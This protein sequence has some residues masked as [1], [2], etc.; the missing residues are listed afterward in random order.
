LLLKNKVVYYE[1]QQPLNDLVHL[2]IFNRNEPF[3]F[4]KIADYLKRNSDTT[5][6]NPEETKR[7]RI[8]L[9]CREITACGRAFVKLKHLLPENLWSSIQV[10]NT[11]NQVNKK[12]SIIL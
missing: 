4:E 1:H 10:T 6:L 3:S 2:T 8:V 12:Y 7:D 5:K 11:L 9:F